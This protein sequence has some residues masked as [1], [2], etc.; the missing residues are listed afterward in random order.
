M[1]DITYDS[2]TAGLISALRSLRLVRS[3]LASKVDYK[4]W[5]F[6]THA[7][8]NDW[9]AQ[10]YTEGDSCCKQLSIWHRCSV[11]VVLSSNVF[12]NIF[13]I[14]TLKETDMGNATGSIE[15]LEACESHQWYR[16]FMTECPSGLLTFY[17]FKKFFGLKNLT[18][19]SN[20]YVMTMFDSFD[21][22]HVRK[23]FI[24]CKMCCF[25]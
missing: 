8:G 15:D 19:A 18:E 6:H 21:I 9:P 4:S 1:S 20:S 23:L 16:K 10:T 14:F 24:L 17:E 12:Y 3:L 11:D 25:V 22:N 13:Y 5:A 2:V 7:L